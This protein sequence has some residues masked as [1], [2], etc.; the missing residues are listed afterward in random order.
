MADAA[1]AR[2]LT[3]ESVDAWNVWRRENDIARVDLSGVDLRGWILDGV[4]LSGADLTDADLRGAGL[5][6]ASLIGARLI[7]TRLDHAVLAECHVG[8]TVFADVDLSVVVGLDA[9]THR[10]SSTIGRDT[11]ER[12]RGM[13]AT[14]FLIGVGCEN[15]TL[16][17]NEMTRHVNAKEDGRLLNE[18]E[19]ALLAAGLVTRFPAAPTEDDVRR[20]RQWRPVHID[21]P[22]VSETIRRFA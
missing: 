19:R 11:I 16:A 21:G 10:G 12:S 17:I 7:R 6:G 1:H 8:E 5:R 4:D 22:P 15:T 13:I 3:T 14:A 20:F 2:Q 9:V 18:V